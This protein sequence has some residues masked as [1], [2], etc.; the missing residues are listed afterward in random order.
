MSPVAMPVSSDSQFATLLEELRT[1]PTAPGNEALSSPWLVAYSFFFNR[2]KSCRRPLSKAGRKGW[3]STFR[4]RI[5]ASDD[6][7]KESKHQSTEI[8][9]SLP[10]SMPLQTTRN[11]VSSV[12]PL[13]WHSNRLPM[14]SVLPLDPSSSHLYL[15]FSIFTWTRAMLSAMLPPQ[16]PKLS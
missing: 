1:A 2:C 4:V 7:S 6:A 3:I 12:N 11:P 8:L 13:H 5:C 14:F 9:L 16:L 15:S 10:L